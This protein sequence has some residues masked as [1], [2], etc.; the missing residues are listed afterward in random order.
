V[1]ATSVTL[2]LS[3]GPQSAAQCYRNYLAAIGLDMKN[4]TIEAI[5][6]LFGNV[7]HP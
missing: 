7:S 6:R 1:N 2:S 4:V 3:D 5:R